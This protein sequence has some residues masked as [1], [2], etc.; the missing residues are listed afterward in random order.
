MMLCFSSK[1]YSYTVPTHKELA[2]KTF[3]LT[4]LNSDPEL[5][6]NLG[7]K[8]IAKGE[9][10]LD[11][12]GAMLTIK[13]LIEEGA[14]YED[15]IPWFLNHF[16][17]PAN[18]VALVS[19]ISDKSPD[20][21]IDG[22]GGH[23]YAYIKARDYYYK[24]LT[25]AMEYER[26]DN[27][28]LTFQSLGHIIH[29]IQDM[30]QPE[31][32]R[33]DPHPPLPGSDWYEKWTEAQVIEN[34]IDSM[35]VPYGNVTFDTPR[36]FWSGGATDGGIATFTNNNFVSKDSNFD[37][38]NNEIVTHTDY[39][40]P[41]PNGINRSESLESLLGEQ[42]RQLC[43]KL[44]NSP[45]LRVPADVTCDVDFVRTTVIDNY[46][47]HVSDNNYASSYSVFDQYL[48][49]FNKTI[50]RYRQSGGS[51]T[52][53]RKFTLN[54][55]N[56]RSAN[57]FLLGRAVS[58]GAGLI[59][60]FFR[61]D[62]EL[63]L[64][65]EGNGWIIVNNSNE[66]LSGDFS[67]YYDD[68]QDIR[69]EI[70][71]AQQ[72]LNIPAGESSAAFNFTTPTFPKPNKTGKYILVFKGVM[73][74]ETDLNGNPMTVIG[75][76]V[77][78]E[79]D[80]YVLDVDTSKILRFD[81]NGNFI[82]TY[83]GSAGSGFINALS[84]YNGDYY[85]NLAHNTRECYNP[86]KVCT[87]TYKNNQLIDQWANGP[88]GT[89]ISANQDYIFTAGQEGDSAVAR[90]FTHD[91]TFV[92]KYLIDPAY[93]Y[94]GGYIGI[95]A[96]NTHFASTFNEN[97]FIFTKTG[98]LV[99][100]QTGIDVSS[101]E[102]AITEDRVMIPNG[103]LAE[104][105]TLNGLRTGNSIAMPDFYRCVSLTEGRLYIVATD[106]SSGSIDNKIYIYNRHVER[107]NNDSII[108][109]NFTFLKTVHINGYVFRA[110]KCSVDRRFLEE[111]EDE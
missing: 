22:V 51:Y 57:S 56:F 2:G 32:V 37:M 65:P 74:E 31:H 84:V 108:S 101:Q 14:Q 47:Q 99:A 28:G 44:K 33:N 55:F 21:I 49:G 11:H 106:L 10:F 103:Y 1:A 52:V 40:L 9:E 23:D 36:E 4:R 90:K 46:I 35:I 76:V 94:Y 78:V 92:G 109:D 48:T 18:D 41:V 8:P 91:G 16:Y 26:N 89:D 15:R 93:A 50:K 100:Q 17:D 71:D 20:W 59:D 85:Y 5:L 69:H 68:K 25:S 83:Y 95:E 3:E 77:N 72:T 53:N 87:S 111:D 58:Y 75:R 104:L 6:K 24:A 12:R 7:L 39:I 43:E 45:R 64:D 79:P 105:Y 19:Y 60:Y 81:P 107:D 42:G 30:S 62:I 54:E 67:L 13:E 102:V 38:L 110:F 61:G 27:W 98:N 70:E 96:N 63:R 86:G 66:S 29:H 88:S 97:L 82:N 73:G 80:F 34:G